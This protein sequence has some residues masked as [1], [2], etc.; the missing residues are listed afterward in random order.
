MN[1]LDHT[2][3]TSSTRDFV[4]GVPIAGRV[5]TRFWQRAWNSET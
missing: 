3:N 4:H 5:T 1:E 2:L